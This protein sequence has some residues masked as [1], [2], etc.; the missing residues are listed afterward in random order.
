MDDNSEF[1]Q[2]PLSE[3][4]RKLTTFI[5]PFGHYFFN[6][7]YHLEFAVLQSILSGV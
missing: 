1:C 4:S 5:T 3:D 6:R 7:S 2:I